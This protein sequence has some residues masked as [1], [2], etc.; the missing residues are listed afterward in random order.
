M[1][2]KILI[3]SGILGVAV[4]VVPPLRTHVAQA[5]DWAAEEV[6]QA[7]PIE[8]QLEQAE[9]ELQRI[10]PEIDE[11]RTLVATEEVEIETLEGQLTRLRQQLAQDTAVLEERSAAL[12]GGNATLVV[13]GRT[14]DREALAYRTKMALE[15]HQRRSQ[16]VQSRQQTLMARM[17][18]LDAAR[19]HL[20]N[21]VGERERLRLAIDELRALMRENQAIEAARG[22]HRFDD[23]KLSDVAK[24]LESIRKKLKIQRRV[25]EQSDPVLGAISRDTEIDPDSVGAEAA[26]YLS[27]LGA[28]T[29]DAPAKLVPAGQ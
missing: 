5:V 19:D 12:G 20:E 18:S 26:R 3:V 6:D 27:G 1:L 9:K 2:K 16:E 7:V 21:M 4:L 22:T 17:K 10:D 28:G 15:R 14:Y 23:S 8:F 29:A 11:A 24:R 13:A 25:I